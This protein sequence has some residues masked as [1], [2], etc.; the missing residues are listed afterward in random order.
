[1]PPPFV[2]HAHGSSAERTA[3]LRA[4]LAAAPLASEAPLRLAAADDAPPAFDAAAYFA[5]LKVRRAV[6]GM[7]HVVH[8][9]LH[10]MA[11]DSSRSALA[12]LCSPSQSC[13]PRRR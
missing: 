9:T 5:A 13:R 2:L 11:L 8:L 4:A 3:T 7:R 12:R 10:R 1:M 6:R